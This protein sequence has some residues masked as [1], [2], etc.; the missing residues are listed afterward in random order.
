MRDD[1]P[2][3]EPPL[4]NLGSLVSA[5]ELLR[6]RALALMQADPDAPV[7][8][9]DRGAYADL[10]AAAHGACGSDAHGGIPGVDAPQELRSVAHLHRSAGLLEHELLLRL[11]QQRAS[12]GR[13]PAE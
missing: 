11:A 13:P 4:S 2:V 7:D 6:T 1:G 3:R 12:R 10:F 9:A 5:A 8:E